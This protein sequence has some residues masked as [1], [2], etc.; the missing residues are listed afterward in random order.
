MGV[1][2]YYW[3]SRFSQLQ[4]SPFFSLRSKRK[5]FTR[6]LLFLAILG[7]LIPLFYSS[8]LFEYWADREDIKFP[9]AQEI[10]V[11]VLAK[12]HNS[13]EFPAASDAFTELFMTHPTF[14]HRV[15]AIVK[16]S[17]IPADRL[18]LVLEEAGMTITATQ[19]SLEEDQKASL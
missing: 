16:Y 2:T 8:R 15:G 1:N 4:P 14:A 13:R 11:Q 18:P 5:I 17:Q 19:T 10:G 3:S 7:P 12:L 6:S 9:H